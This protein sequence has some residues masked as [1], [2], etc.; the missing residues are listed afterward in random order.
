[1][2]DKRFLTN[3]DFNKA[4]PAE[5]SAL[6]KVVGLKKKSST[7]IHFTKY[8]DVNFKTISIAKAKQLVKLKFPYLVAKPIAKTKE[9]EDNGE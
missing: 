1:M 9:P 7:N 6:F 5:V 3:T 4:L 2:S 8:G